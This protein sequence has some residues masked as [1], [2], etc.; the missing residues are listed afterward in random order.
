MDNGP[1]AQKPSTSFVALKL[2]AL[3]VALA[4][5]ACVIV[6]IKLKEKFCINSTECMKRSI[7]PPLLVHAN[8]IF[9][10]ISSG[11][12]FAYSDCQMGGSTEIVGI[13]IRNITIIIAN[14]CIPSNLIY[15]V[16]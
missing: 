13:I 12:C 6:A 11:F 15:S 9:Q 2:S 7:H 4:I 1:T 10:L 3:F 8:Q 14:F 5:V 16:T